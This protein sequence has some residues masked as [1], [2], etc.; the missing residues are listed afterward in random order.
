M[1]DQGVTNLCLNQLTSARARRETY[2]GQW[3]PEPV[4]D[5]DRCS[6]RPIPSSSSIVMLTLMERLSAKERVVYVLRT[7]FGYAHNEI[8][9]M[10]DITE[11]ETIADGLR[12]RNS[13]GVAGRQRARFPGWADGDRLRCHLTN[14]CSRATDRAASRTAGA[15]S[16]Q[17]SSHVATDNRML[18]V[19]TNS[20]GCAASRAVCGC[21]SIRAEDRAMGGSVPLLYG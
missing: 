9:D 8:A 11:R 20:S 16:P 15:V 5:G 7:A 4:F 1:A 14:P 17:A 21:A 10:L 3:L 19:A 13:D 6:A 2:V 12:H 18:S